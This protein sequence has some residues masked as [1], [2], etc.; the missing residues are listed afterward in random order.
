MVKVPSELAHAVNSQGERTNRLVER[1][2][3]SLHRR[4][5]ER[6]R[7][8]DKTAWRKAETYSYIQWEKVN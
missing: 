1:R 5:K 4:K 2:G 6:H 8:R 7:E 3:C